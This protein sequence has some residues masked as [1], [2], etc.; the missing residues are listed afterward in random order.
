MATVKALA[1]KLVRSPVAMAASGAAAV[2]G[3]AAA[4]AAA[5]LLGPRMRGFAEIGEGQ[6]LPPGDAPA[7]YLPSPRPAPTD[8]MVRYLRTFY[9]PHY[10]NVTRLFARPAPGML[11]FNRSVNKLQF[12]DGARWVQLGSVNTGQLYPHGKLGA[13][14]FDRQ[15]N[16]VTFDAGTHWERVQHLAGNAPEPR[17]HEGAGVGAIAFDPDRRLYL[18]RL[19]TGWRTLRTEAA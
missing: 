3:L 14:F 1:K 18:T 11:I 5:V 12:W 16:M 9:P 10:S 4:A 13:T 15:E 17:G 2:A 8:A 19:N 7:G 6:R